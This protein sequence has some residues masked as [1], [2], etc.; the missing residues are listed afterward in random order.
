[1]NINYQDK[2]KN[3]ENENSKTLG[4][5]SIQKKEVKNAIELI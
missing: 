5:A 1:M 4:K 2:S 3:R